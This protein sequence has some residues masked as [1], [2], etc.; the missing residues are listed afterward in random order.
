MQYCNSV[1]HSELNEDIP[2]NAPSLTRSNTMQNYLIQCAY[3][4]YNIANIS[5]KIH[6][7]AIPSSQQTIGL[8]HIYCAYVSLLELQGSLQPNLTV[9]STNVRRSCFTSFS[10]H[11]KYLFSFYSL[12][13]L[14]FFSCLKILSGIR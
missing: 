8:H 7:S 4:C 2:R 6:E 5:T 12:M 3:F 14:S 10:F 9:F 11:S 1:F 13:L